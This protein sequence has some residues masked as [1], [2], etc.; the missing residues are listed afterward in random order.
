MD[1]FIN[2]TVV[3][4][5]GVR[6]STD[7]DGSSIL[8]ITRNR[9]YSVMGVGSDVWEIVGNAQCGI[10]FGQVAEQVCERFKGVSRI[11]IESDVEKLLRSFSS[12][13]LIVPACNAPVHGVR[14]KAVVLVTALLAHVAGMLVRLR[15]SLIP[16]LIGLAMIDLLIISGNFQTLYYTIKSWP[17]RP[18][19]EV[20]PLE[21]VY[22]TLLTALS[23]YPKQ[24]LCLQRSAVTTCLLRSSGIGAQ[25]II[26]CKKL[27]FLAHAWV[28]VNGQV[29]GDKKSVQDLHAILDRC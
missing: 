22:A 7:D 16:V 3:V 11:R 18:V 21:N 29:V 1:D 23:W 4:A 5:S 24:A 28:E 15:L 14:T 12:H 27:P 8:H 25:M 6:W 19:T 10:S 17:V 20:P 26:G 9:M 2:Q 13:H